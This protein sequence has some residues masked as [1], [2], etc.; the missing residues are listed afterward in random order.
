MTE[1]KSH[2]ARQR[3]YRARL[4][5]VEAARL[6]PEFRAWLQFRHRAEQTRKHYGWRVQRL[7]RLLGANGVS[8]QKATTADLVAVW[9]S[10]GPSYHNGLLEAL[11]AFYKFA[12]EKGY[13]RV[14]MNPALGLE[15]VRK[16]KRLPRPYGEQ[17]R[18]RYLSAALALGPRYYA[19]ACL[20]VYAGLRVAEV[21]ALPWA[22]VGDRL[23]V[24]GKGNKERVVPVAKPLKEALEAW[25]SVCPSTRWL[26]PPLETAR[27]G[28]NNGSKPVHAC[29]VW[30]WHRE[31]LKRAG[32]YTGEHGRDG[33]HRLR[34]KAVTAVYRSSGRDLLTTARFAGHASVGTTA[35]YALVEDD[36]VEQAV[37]GMYG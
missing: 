6:L 28:P 4:E 24:V 32:L 11:R 21:A 2:A 8:L 1:D 37:K 12:Q 23:R 7:A 16:P 9:P 15:K 19:T 25:R 36:D 31:V 22:A 18:T 33:F 20:G 30:V 17:E 26:F 14:G 27:G 35:V 29:R 34:H 5:M 3:R 10:V 13:V